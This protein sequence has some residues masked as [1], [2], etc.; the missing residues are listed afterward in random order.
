MRQE[1]GD[2]RQEAGDTRHAN[3]ARW[4]GRH[5][6]FGSGNGLRTAGGICRSRGGTSRGSRSS[7]HPLQRSHL[8][9]SLSL[10]IHIYKY[11]IP[12]CVYIYIYT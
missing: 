3:V 1:T 10:Y 4:P 11:I 6:F 12:Q 9:L 8:S 5:P 2:R 7:N